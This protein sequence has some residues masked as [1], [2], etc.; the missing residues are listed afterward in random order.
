MSRYSI[1]VDTDPNISSESR[2]KISTGVTEDLCN[3]NTSVFDLLS[4]VDRCNEKDEIDD[5]N[6]KAEDLAII[7]SMIDE[8]VSHI[9]IGG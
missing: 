5:F 8:G 6:L 7:K 3:H 9:E 4:I 2:D 1:V